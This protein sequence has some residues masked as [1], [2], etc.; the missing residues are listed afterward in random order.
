L[1]IADCIATMG[2]GRSLRVHHD[3]SNSDADTAMDAQRLSTGR[4][5][6]FR[7]LSSVSSSLDAARKARCAC[8]SACKS[9]ESLLVARHCEQRLFLQFTTRSICAMRKV[10][11]Q[12]NGWRSLVGDDASTPLSQS[13]SCTTVA[14]AGRTFDIVSLQ[15]RSA[16]TG[17]WAALLCCATAELAAGASRT[18]SPTCSTR[19]HH[20]SAEGA[21][22]SV[23]CS[24]ECDLDW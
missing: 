9:S 5:V 3:G 19:M 17:F 14:D 12:A 7:A 2:N 18:Q 1:H 22:G 6:P 20:M 16:H 4:T 10:S 21:T 8:S 11:L 24:S 23:V 13:P 15:P